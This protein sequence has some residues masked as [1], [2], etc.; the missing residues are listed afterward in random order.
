MILPTRT[1][2][3]DLDRE[4][5]R[6]FGKESVLPPE[7]IERKVLRPAAVLFEDLDKEYERI[8]G[9]PAV[10]PEAP[11]ALPPKP[12]LWERV[13]GIWPWKKPPEF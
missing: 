7:K 10:V 3:E 1:D 8:T 9:K 12:S 6:L 11:P 4:Y 2:L 5:S 13:K